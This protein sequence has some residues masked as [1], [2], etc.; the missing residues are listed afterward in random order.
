MSV[1][2]SKRL[3]YYLSG[4]VQVHVVFVFVQ[5]VYCIVCNLLCEQIKKKN[6]KKKQSKL[7]R[8]NILMPQTVKVILQIITTLYVDVL[9]PT[10]PQNVFQKYSAMPSTTNLDIHVSNYIK[11][12]EV[13]LSA[14]I[15]RLFHK[16]FS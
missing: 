3:I 6:K 15:C 1:E 16:N 14:F 7:K 10:L 5:S 13:N 12:S 4:R 2:V 8:H 9:S 11:I